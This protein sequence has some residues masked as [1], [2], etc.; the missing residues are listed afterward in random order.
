[1]QEA[2]LRG[3]RRAPLARLLWYRNAS[4]PKRADAL[5]SALSIALPS[6]EKPI[7]LSTQTTGQLTKG[8]DYWHQEDISKR[9]SENM[10]A[11]S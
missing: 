9:F 7:N 3:C 1:M 2:L 11:K 10:E 6:E 4:M 8:F 5:Q